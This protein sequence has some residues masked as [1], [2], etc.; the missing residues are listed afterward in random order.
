MNGPF[1][2]FMMKSG[3]EWSPKKSYRNEVLKINKFEIN[4]QTVYATTP[5]TTRFQLLQWV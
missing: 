4:F 5:I 2:C 1:L 3:S